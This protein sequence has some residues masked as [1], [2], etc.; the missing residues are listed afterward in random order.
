MLEQ[1]EKPTKPCQHYMQNN[2]LNLL[3][4]NKFLLPQDIGSPFIIEDN[5]EWMLENC[6]FSIF[7][8][9]KKDFINFVS[10]NFDK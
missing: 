1:F 6:A 9:P 10:D 3:I 7:Y 8:L 2:F 5:I 4:H